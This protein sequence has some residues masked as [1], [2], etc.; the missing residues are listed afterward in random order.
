MRIFV[1]LTLLVAVVA[2]AAGCRSTRGSA[3]GQP[4]SNNNR[5]PFWAKDRNGP[6]LQSPT[7]RDDTGTR[8]TSAEQPDYR[9]VLAGRLVD[10]GNRRVA[11]AY[12]Q[13]SGPE[14]SGKPIEIAADDDG[15]F[16]IPGLQAG[17]SYM[18]TARAHVDGRLLAGRVQATPPQPR[19]VIRLTEDI[20]TGSVPALPPHPGDVLPGREPLPPRPFANVPDN[21][22]GA[23]PSP[24]INQDPGW[25]P[26]SAPRSPAP[27]DPSNPPRIEPVDL[28]NVAEQNKS[29][30]PKLERPP[31]T[32]IPSGPKVPDPDPVP[33]GAMRV[34]S[35]TVVPS[36]YLSGRRL[37]NF[38]LNDIDG[39]P[40]EFRNHHG[41]LVLLDFWGTWCPHCLR[42]MPELVELQRQYGAYGL[43][44]VGI[45]CEQD[46]GADAE[47]KVRAAM[48][49][50]RVNY[51]VLLA[52]E[53]G[54]CPVQRQLAIDRW[55]T[56]ILLDDFGNILYRAS[57]GSLEPLKAIIRQ[58]LGRK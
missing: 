14:S 23:T 36:A 53:R 44:I 55:P 10:A 52:E 8:L 49:K 58:R 54:K 28:E 25:S 12:V 37:V 33:N 35:Q 32:N 42:A 20:A 13:V 9:G 17:R 11:K 43:E 40:W 47:R 38:A 48:Q 56:V 3:T 24:R 22:A 45:A 16:L 46:S 5:T 31:V 29:R 7:V 4:T 34:P 39:R 15:Y 41:R 26:G 18:L 21:R 2:V 51:Q 50:Y 57:G 1:R 27:V 19:L 6:K 30:D